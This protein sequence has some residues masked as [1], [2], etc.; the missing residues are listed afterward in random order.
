MMNFYGMR[1]TNSEAEFRADSKTNKAMAKRIS[2]YELARGNQNINNSESID[3][4]RHVIFS[5]LPHTIDVDCSTYPPFL[6]AFV[7]LNS[8]TWLC[9]I[10]YIIS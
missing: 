5:L 6:L 9:S 8:S 3:I 10:H 4:D 1:K 7:G 2:N